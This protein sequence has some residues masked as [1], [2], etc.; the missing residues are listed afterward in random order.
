VTS[1]SLSTGSWAAGYGRPRIMGRP[2][3]L[4]R[5][6]LERSSCEYYEVVGGTSTVSAFVNRRRAHV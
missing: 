1:M 2:R 3:I 5:I 4:E 6:R